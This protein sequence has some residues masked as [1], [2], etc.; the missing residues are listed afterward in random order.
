MTKRSGTGKSARIIKT[1]FHER[2]NI[3]LKVE[4]ARLRFMNRVRNRIFLNF[5]DVEKDIKLEVYWQIAN[6]LGEEF[7]RPSPSVS[8][9]DYYVGGDF[10]KCLQAIEAI[11]AALSTKPNIQKLNILVSIILEESEIDLGIG[12]ENGRFIR[13]GAGLLDQKLVNEPLRWLSDPKY[14]NV[15]IP[16]EKGLGHFLKAEKNLDLL[17]DVVRN[18]YEALE[19]LSKVITGRHNKDLSANAE[20][21]IK[22]IRASEA[23]KKILREYIDYANKFRHAPKEGE[24]KPETSVSEVESF[25]YLT[26]IFIRL[27]LES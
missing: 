23:Y 4:Q 21:F 12:W 8:Y 14:K 19:A 20:L 1:P 5:I 11:H 10:H 22:K 9:F 16:F 3:Q 7:R 18:V 27:A 15:Y 13:T 2:F 26:G 25:I 17:S 24:Q 6:T